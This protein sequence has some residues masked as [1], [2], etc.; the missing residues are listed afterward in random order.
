MNTFQLFKTSQPSD[1]DV[2]RRRN[3]VF[4]RCQSS[5][6][7]TSKLESPAGEFAIFSHSSET[8]VLETQSE[9]ESFKP[10]LHVPDLSTNCR[11]LKFVQAKFSIPPNDSKPSKAK[12][13][14]EIF[15]PTNRPHEDRSSYWS[16]I[17]R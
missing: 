1:P 2:A 11:L 10:A 6:K 3:D 16:T 7:I 8:D 9:I 5:R 17:Y 15:R 13:D 12:I 14:N 4:E